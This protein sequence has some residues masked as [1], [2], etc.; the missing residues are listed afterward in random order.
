MHILKNNMN[1]E[2]LKEFI[3]VAHIRNI[4]RAAKVLFTTPSVIS[5]H[6][7]SLEKDLCTRLLERDTHHVSLTRKGEIFLNQIEPLMIEITNIIAFMSSDTACGLKIIINH[8]DAYP[9]FFAFLNKYKELYPDIPISL[10]NSDPD[11]IMTTLLMHE[12]DLAITMQNPKLE[13]SDFNEIIIDNMQIYIAIPKTLYSENEEESFNI[14]RSGK[15]YIPDTQKNPG[16]MN[17][18]EQIT[19][20]QNIIVSDI[21]E[22]PDFESIIMMIKHDPAMALVPKHY[23]KFLPKNVNIISIPELPTIPLV[24][25]WLSSNKNSNIASFITLLK[26]HELII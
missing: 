23:V 6:M 13:R 1:I 7:Q 10:M 5:R 20:Q 15:L 18:L 4:S 21:Q 17:V 3:V 24:A 12:A 11:S 8:L 22:L 14:L 19:K 9:K 2:Y 16:V 25:A 26:Q